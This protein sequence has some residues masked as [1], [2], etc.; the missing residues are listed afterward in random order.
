[1][2]RRTS[3]Y[4]DSPMTEQGS[5][6]RML[7]G[8]TL[9]GVAALTG[10]SAAQET[11]RCPNATATQAA[12]AKLTP[13]APPESGGAGGLPTF[14]EGVGLSEWLPY[15]DYDVRV[16]S[17]ST[18][19][20]RASQPQ[21]RIDSVLVEECGPSDQAVAVVHNGFTVADGAGRAV[22]SFA[23]QLVSGDV[24]ED[25]PRRLAPGT[26]AKTVLAMALPRSADPATVHDGS[27]ITWVLP[28]N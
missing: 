5:V 22:G 3:S 20:A 19:A 9:V 25:P 2:R 26:C 13:P 27:T 12:C 7:I 16:L 23:G 15:R 21:S 10:C 28:G 14:S 6:A 8:L 24:T 1:M 17:Y 11:A 4:A 18:Y